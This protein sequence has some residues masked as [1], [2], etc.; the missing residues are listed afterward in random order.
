MVPGIVDRRGRM[1]AAANERV[2]VGVPRHAGED[3]GDLHPGDIGL[4][5]SM[6]TANFRRRVGLGV[7]G[8]ELRRAAHEHQKD[9]VNVRLALV[10]GPQGLQLEKLGK[11]QAQE[12]QR[13][14]MEKITAA[15]PITELNGTIGIETDHT[16]TS[17][18]LIQHQFD[19]TIFG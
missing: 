2:L 14:G 6:G 12:S 7:P 4:D 16:R 17:P 10:H 19:D 1:V 8:I 3:L 18:R 9:A 13:A 15:Q 5:R 11:T